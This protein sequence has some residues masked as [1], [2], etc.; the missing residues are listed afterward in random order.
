[1]HSAVV[2]ETETVATAAANQDQRP[3]KIDSCT[4]YSHIMD[5]KM[6][7]FKK[8][9][10]SLETK[11]SKS[12]GAWASTITP[13]GCTPR[14]EFAADVF[15]CVKHLEQRL[16]HVEQIINATGE[17]PCRSF[18]K[19]ICGFPDGFEA[20]AEKQRQAL[21]KM[22]ERLCSLRD[23]VAT[24]MHELS[25]AATLQL[26]LWKQCTS[27]VM[28]LVN[29]TLDQRLG[30]PGGLE[31]RLEIMQKDVVG[32]RILLENL[33]PLQG[34]NRKELT[35]SKKEL[36]CA[37]LAH[38]EFSSHSVT[39]LPVRSV[40]A[41]APSSMSAGDVDNT[42]SAVVPLA[43]NEE[44]FDSAANRSQAAVA[45]STSPQLAGPDTT[46]AQATDSRTSP[47]RLRGRSP[48]WLRS[49]VQKSRLLRPR[50]SLDSV[51]ECRQQQPTKELQHQQQQW[52]LLGQVQGPQRITI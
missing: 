6:D 3:S 52:Q 50:P 42:E 24:C 26:D 14:A 29:S 32:H 47:P 15:S 22:E 10:D 44:R 18:A 43:A 37:K 51:A 40:P 13:I 11:E 31:E 2:L 4:N 38:S 12:E 36:D 21:A 17:S 9:V 35:N 27:E 25:K 7:P 28:L 30:S 41:S 1:M 20:Q 33:E 45:Q 34:H 23:E 46:I 39:T 49:S 48:R 19:P 8:A 16:H 5:T